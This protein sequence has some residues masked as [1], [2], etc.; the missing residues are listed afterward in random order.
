MLVDFA[1]TLLESLLKPFNASCIGSAIEAWIDFPAFDQTEGIPDFVGKVSSLLY[2]LVVVGEVI[3]RRGREKH[4]CTYA[5]G[6]IL[7]DKLEGIWGVAQGLGHLS[8][9][10]VA[11][12]TREVHVFE[13][14]LAH[15]FVASNDHTCYPEE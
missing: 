2:E 6:T 15:V 4:A 8:A 12:N 10:F 9:E 14:L 5:I 13:R 3:S 11:H 1:K 7:S